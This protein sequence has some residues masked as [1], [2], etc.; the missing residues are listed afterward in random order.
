M[1]GPFGGRLGWGQQPALLL[2]DVVNAY[3]VPGS[4]LDLGAAGAP[5]VRAGR[6]AAR[7]TDRQVSRPAP[8]RQ[9]T[10]C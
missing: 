3:L 9:P 2:V 8:G 1:S 10:W 7:T 4:P 6:S 5:V